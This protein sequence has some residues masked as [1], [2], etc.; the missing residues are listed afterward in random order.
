MNPSEELFKQIKSI[1]EELHHLRRY[2][3]DDNL[4]KTP[5]LVSLVREN[6][7]EIEKLKQRNAIKDVKAGMWGM[8]GAGTLYIGK[9]IFDFFTSKH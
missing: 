5:G 2:L 4:T 3:I 8:I 9:L 7:A 1:N 6:T